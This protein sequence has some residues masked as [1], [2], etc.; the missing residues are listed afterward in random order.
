MINK[1]LHWFAHLLGRN[2]GNVITFIEDGYICVAFKCN[3]G[4]ICPKS[5]DKIE[6]EIVY[7][8]RD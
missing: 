6:S 8:K 4:Y 2:E 7:A 5:I 1:V 3:C